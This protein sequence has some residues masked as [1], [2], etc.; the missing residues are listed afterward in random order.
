NKGCIQI[1]V[2]K[3][4]DYVSF[5]VFDNGKGISPENQKKLFQPFFTS[6][7]IKGT[8]LG[9]AIVK[10]IVSAHNGFIN[11]RSVQGQ[12]TCFVIRIPIDG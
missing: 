7:K 11:L 8:G 6:G 3:T 12:Y 9:L 2:K 1:K 4:G 5:T 10:D